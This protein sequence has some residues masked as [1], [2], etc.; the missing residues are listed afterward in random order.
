MMIALIFQGQTA[1]RLLT[2]M[3][4]PQTRSALLQPLSSLQ[5]KIGGAEIS[6]DTKI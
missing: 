6:L 1:N 5:I 4:C 2:L 3:K